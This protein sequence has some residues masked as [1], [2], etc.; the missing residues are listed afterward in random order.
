M[1]NKKIKWLRILAVITFPLWIIPLMLLGLIS[2]I[3]LGFIEL[4]QDIYYWCVESEPKPLIRYKS[5]DDDEYPNDDE[6]PSW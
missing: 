1:K 2:A 4:G 5:Y 3:L 6:Y